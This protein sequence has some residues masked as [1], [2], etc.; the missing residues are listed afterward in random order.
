MEANNSY[1]LRVGMI[2]ESA[3][4]A[5]AFVSAYAAHNNFAVKN[6]VVKHTD[7]TLL[8]CTCNRKPLNT[9]NLP[10]EVGATGGNGL[11]RHRVARSM[12]CDCP[13]KV[14]LTKQFNDSWILRELIDEHQRRQ[15]EGVNPLAYSENRSMTAE[16]RQSVIDLQHQ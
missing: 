16:A 1:D 4:E 8:V 13:W 11:I 6:G 12:Q 9:R 7:Q 2:F 3:A 15:L 5:R 14:R 10:M